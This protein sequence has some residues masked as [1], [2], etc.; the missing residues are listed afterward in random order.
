MPSNPKPS[1][2]QVI[3]IYRIK[4]MA[5]GKAYIG[6]TSG[7][8]EARFNQHRSKADNGSKHLLHAAIRKYGADSFTTECLA[9][10]HT[11]DEGYDLEKKF[12]A[13][14]KT[15]GLGYNMTGGGETPD[16]A[17]C[18]EYAT[19][20]WSRPAFRILR[21]Q[22]AVHRRRSKAART[23]AKDIWSRP[24]FRAARTNAAAKRS[25]GASEPSKG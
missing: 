19:E 3:S 16:P 7:T 23:S 5:N 24:E 18:S 10:A 2:S 9:V 13:D 21:K 25:H 8:I 22:R 20:I 17:L 15:H 4:N 12:I 6:Q 1:A 11:E 14:Q